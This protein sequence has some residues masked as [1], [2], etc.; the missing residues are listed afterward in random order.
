[1]IA[2]LECAANLLE[3]PEW[4]WERQ[5]RPE[6][7][8]PAGDW[9]V[10]LLLAGR[11]FGKSRAGAEWLAR[12]AATQ[13]GRHFAVIARS[14][15]D[16][17]DTCIEGPSGLLVALGLVRDSREYNRVTGK[18][19]L[20][21]GAVIHS[22]SAERP[23]QLRGPNL[24]GCWADELASWRYEETWTHGL[25]PALRIGNPRV[26]ATTTPKRTRL[27]RELLKRQDGSVIV[28]RGSTF[29]NA[30]NLSPNALQELRRRY[31]GTRLGRQEL[32]GELLDDVEG[33]LW[34]EALLASRARWMVAPDTLERAR[35]PGRPP[36]RR[37]R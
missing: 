11:G 18:I 2:A 15:P 7:L 6:Q 13:P 25:I 8:P 29:D 17:R 22:Y 34:S 3:P 28:V 23:D 9:F 35:L 31:E 36:E 12:Q 26:V 37:R 16:V 20:A 4:P 33:A 27:L 1:M 32:Y 24:A 14:R 21:N 10:W 30:A 19:R 5:A